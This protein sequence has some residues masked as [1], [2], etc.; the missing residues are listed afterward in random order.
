MSGDLYL[1]GAYRETPSNTNYFV[2][3]R[4]DS[5][6]NFKYTSFYLG[7]VDVKA[8]SINDAE[9]KIGVLVRELDFSL[10]IFDTATGDVILKKTTTALGQILTPILHLNHDGSS[11][12]LMLQEAITW[13]FH[14]CKL[15][16]SSGSMDC[17]EREN[18]YSIPVEMKPSRTLTTSS[19]RSSGDT[20]TI[21]S[22]SDSGKS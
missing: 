8:F 15:V 12:I 11:T 9:T 5:Q 19:S 22:C 2:I 20:Y 18:E 17:Y 3:S 1:F 7:K 21:C 6:D 14:I 16:I 13:D 10:V 4:L